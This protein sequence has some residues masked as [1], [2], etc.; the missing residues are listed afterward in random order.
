MLYKNEIDLKWQ[1]QHFPP[2]HPLPSLSFWDSVPEG[3]CTEGCKGVFS[4]S[5]FPYSYPYLTPPGK[6]EGIPSMK[7]GLQ[8]PEPGQAP[9]P[10]LLAFE[11][12]PQAPR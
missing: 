9:R 7:P 3:Q 4:L 10:H 8:A 5:T 1:V 12:G 6:T 2:A 11:S